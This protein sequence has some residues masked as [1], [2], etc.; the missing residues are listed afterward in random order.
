V[1]TRELANG[2]HVLGVRILDSSGAAVFVPAL[3]RY[4]MNVFIEN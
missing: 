4:G 2:P 3:V 1:D